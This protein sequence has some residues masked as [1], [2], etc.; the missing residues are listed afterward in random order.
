MRCFKYVIM[1]LLAVGFS[2]DLSAGGPVSV[3]DV[4]NSGIAR[5]WP[6]NTL[7][8]YS[9]AGRLAST[10]DHAK[11]VEWVNEAFKK[12]LD[13]KLRDANGADLETSSVKVVYKG[14]LQDGGKDV[15][16]NVDNFLSTYQSGVPPS[17]IFDENGDI[18]ANLH[19]E[20]NRSIELGLTAQAGPSRDDTG[21]YITRG[22][23]ILNGYFLSKNIISEKRF[24]TAIL[25]ELGHLLNL[26]HT[27]VGLE[28]A[29][30]CTEES[31]TDGAYIPTMYP[32]NETEYQ[33]D[34][35]RD[36]EISLS[37]IYPTDD[38]NKNFCTIT[39]EVLDADGKTLKGVNVVA[40]RANEG[41]TM[42][43]VDIRSFVSGAMTSL[44]EGKGVYYLK[45]IVPKAKYQ[46]YYEPVGAEFSGSS[47]LEPLGEKSPAGFKKGNINSP[48]G[49]TT[50]S[51][52]SGGETIEMPATTISDAKSTCKADGTAP[53]TDS[54]SKTQA[55]SGSKCS[56]WPVGGV[57]DFSL[58]YILAAAVIIGIRRA[59][60]V[61]R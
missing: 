13:F 12:W 32:T 19:G 27:Q 53:P 6:N 28:I 1:L 22:V 36:D 14:N 3:D 38:F 34:L 46:I 37:A 29:K 26:D 48:S 30:E 17:V 20:G 43:N 33:Y 59:V 31:C 55:S 18:I 56:L 45:G 42:Q 10:V 11:S 35:S 52:A 58:L 24:K 2:R 39:G 49:G 7:E 51:C 44:C 54:E 5:R 16:V 60:V 15:T 47:D 57:C 8:W 40:L 61:K 21:K 50:V 9:S 23:V 41:E 4:N 25:H